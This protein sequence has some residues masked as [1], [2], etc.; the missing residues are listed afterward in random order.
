MA[1]SVAEARHDL[2]DLYGLPSGSLVE[3]TLGAR[4]RLV[5][6]S[7]APV[8]DLRPGW[9]AVYQ[10]K[11]SSKRRSMHRK[12]LA[13]LGELGSVEVTVA[14][15]IE[16][17][18]PA[19]EDALRLHALR[20]RNRPDG[21]TFAEPLGPTFQR[22]A[23]PALAAAGVARIT[24]L[25]VDGRPVAFRYYLLVEGRM[26][27]NGTGYD[28]AFASCSPGWVLML[29]TLEAAAAEGAH[30]VEF[31]GG[32]EPY[33]LQFADRLDPLYEAIGLPGSA[34]GSVA[35]AVRISTINVRRKMREHDGIRRFYYDGLA[36]IRRAARRLQGL[37][38]R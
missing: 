7:E 22:A 15:T 21:S 14:Q 27:G 24:R 13:Q 18:A 36:P 29:A 5:K 12:R 2:V 4:L 32:D 17:L 31:L 8:L 25:L 9:A 16:E 19:L 28:P 11:L 23:L 1:R 26:V 33:K 10:S 35:A 34:R 20:W 3:T 30:T 37:P 38:R 6:R